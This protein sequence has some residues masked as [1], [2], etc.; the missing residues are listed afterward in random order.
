MTDSGCTTT[1]IFSGSTPNS[2]LASMTSK[3]LFIIV[4]ESM[5][6]LLPILQFG[7]LSAS[8]ATA[9]AIR[10]FSQV[11]KGPPEAVRCSFAISFPAEPIRHWKIAECSESTGRICTLCSAASLITSSPAATRVS[12]FAR[13]MVLPASMAATVER[14]PLKPTIEVSTMSISED[15]TRSHTDCIPANTFIIRGCKASA[16]LAYRDSLH[17][18]TLLA[19]NSSA[20]SM[21]R[22]AL[23]LATMSSK[24]KRSG[25]CLSTSSA[26]LPMDPVEPSIATPLFFIMSYTFEDPQPRPCTRDQT[27]D[28]LPQKDFP[29]C[30]PGPPEYPH[31][32]CRLSS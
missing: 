14:N 2:H 3:P 1:L 26:C 27:S 11:L 21:S 32:L 16:T 5:V 18:T 13:A 15:P 10:D 30:R 29:H 17:I 6:I 4:A 28:G 22:S 12:L 23:L 24:L 7:C 25:C 9:S 31:A 19:S 8:E 20:C